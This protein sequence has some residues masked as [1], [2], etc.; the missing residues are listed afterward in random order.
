M[1]LC[2]ILT[3]PKN[4]I[5]TIKKNGFVALSVGIRNIKPP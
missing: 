5:K 3:L 2:S 1:S 4:L